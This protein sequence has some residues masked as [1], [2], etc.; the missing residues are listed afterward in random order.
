MIGFSSHRRVQER[1]GDRSF[2]LLCLTA[3]FV[4]L[5]HA[6]HLPVW[7]TATFAAALGWRWW[8]RQH[9]PGRVPTWLKLP[10]MLLLFAIVIRIY[11]NVFGRE[12]NCKSRFH[13]DAN[14]GRPCSPSVSTTSSGGNPR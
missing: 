2:D 4:L 14:S 7:L 11:G 3:A 6:S 12:L 10:A 13:G 5:V 1:L 8:Q 9:R